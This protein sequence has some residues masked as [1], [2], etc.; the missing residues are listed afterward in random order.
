MERSV[1]SVIGVVVVLVV[2]FVGRSISIGEAGGKM[3]KQALEMVQHVEGFNDR[4]DY[5]Y[6]LVDMGHD[7]VFD[8]CREVVRTGRRSRRVVVDEEKYYHSLLTWMMTQAGKD[9]ATHV[10]A[11][12]Q[13]FRDD[14][15]MAL[16]AMP[17]QRRE[18]L[19]RQG[20]G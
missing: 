4:P 20:G 13:K 3:K 2:V 8:D 18:F 19:Q 15:F 16:D 6:W 9:N 17:A 1:W 11:A 5:Y 10:A 12:L 7:A 14:N